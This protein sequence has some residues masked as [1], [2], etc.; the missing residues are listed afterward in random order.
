MSRLYRP[1]ID[2]PTTASDDPRVGHLLG[3]S[4]SEETAKVVLLGFPSDEG[5]RINGG[6]P[7]AAHGPQAIRERLYRMTPDARQAGHYGQLL[8]QTYDL[9]DVAVTGKV[10]RDQEA[11]GR[12]LKPHLA[13]GAVPVILGGGHET[14]FGHFLGYVNAGRSVAIMNWDA[15]PDVRP[16]KAGRAHSGSP[17]RQS[18]LHESGMCRSYSVLGLSSH[19]T[20]SAHVEFIREHGGSVMWN[21]AL[22]EGEVSKAFDGAEGPLMVS[23]DL[24]AVDQ[25]EAPGV[26][27]PCAAG[28]SSRLW[29][30]AAYEAGRC[31]AATSF[32][33]V[34][35]NPTVDVDDRTARLAAL[36]VWSILHGLAARPGDRAPRASEE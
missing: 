22:T 27:A 20:S 17:F 2:V 33:V 19:Q 1:K 29:R 36:T 7:G 31:S 11:L 14:A 35:L 26:S 23:F 15:H 32:D 21:D 9:G 18:I 16:M 34:E 8:G 4:C 3:R 28:M 30:R 6:R 24:D 12:I 10:E 5:V 25:S 13:R